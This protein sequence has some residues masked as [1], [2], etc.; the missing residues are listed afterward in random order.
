MAK[1]LRSKSKRAARSLK[2]KLVFAPVEDERLQRLAKKQAVITDP[3]SD[4]AMDDT[5][6][7]NTDMDVVLSKNAIK[8]LAM[9]KHQLYKKSKAKK[10]K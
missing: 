1:S 4:M 8:R 7:E 2:R 9:S 10:R 5:V 3:I 6:I